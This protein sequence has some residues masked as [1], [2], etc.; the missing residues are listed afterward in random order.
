ML[1]AIFHFISLVFYLKLDITCKNLFP[2]PRCCTSRNFLFRKSS[3]LG[4][5]DFSHVIFFSGVIFIVG[6]VPILFYSSLFL[7]WS[8]F[9]FIFRAILNLVVVLSLSSLD[10]NWPMNQFSW[11]SVHT[12]ADKRFKCACTFYRSYVHV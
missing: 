3:F 9:W 12:N 4:Q 10:I 7:K 8:Y 2:F 1:L 5:V 11:R 6:L